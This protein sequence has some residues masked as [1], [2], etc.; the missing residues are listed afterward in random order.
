MQIVNQEIY[1]YRRNKVV[2][3]AEVEDYKQIS[4][5]LLATAMKNLEYYGYTFS[6]SL[7]SAL[8]KT[9]KEL[10]LEWMEE[11]NCILDDMVGFKEGMY[12]LFEDFPLNLMTSSESD[13]Y[14]MSL[15]RYL[16]SGVVH[17]KKQLKKNY[18]LLDNPK[19][20][21]IDLGSEDDFLSIFTNLLS[22]KTAISETDKETISWFVMHP[23]MPLSEII[24]TEI[25]NKENLTFITITMRESGLSNKKLLNNYKTATDVLRFAVAL[26]GG[27]ISLKEKTKFKSFKRSDRRL[28]LS[29]LEN[30]PFI[31]ED[32][33]RRKSEWIRLGEKLHPAEYKKF[34]KVNRAFHKLRN[35]KP[36]KTFK[37]ELEKHFSN[38]DLEKVLFLLSKRPGEF[39]RQLDRT[40]RLAI[41]LN[42]LKGDMSSTLKVMNAFREV[43]DKIET[44]V[45]LQLRQHLMNRTKERDFRVFYPKGSMAKAYGVENQIQPLS[46]DIVLEFVAIC[47][48]ALISKYGE[49]EDMGKVFISDE[50]K[51]YVVPMSQRNASKTLRAVARGS[52]FKIEEDNDIVRAFI[53]WKQ[54]SEHTWGVDVDLSAV[55]YDED[56][57]YI[58]DIS[59]CHLEGK[60]INAK[61][62]G[63]VRSAPKGASEYIDM[64][65]N[66]LIANDVKYVSFVI[67]SF[68]E[69]LFSELPEC[70]AGF[71]SREDIKSGEVYEPKTVINKSDIASNSYQVIPMILDVENR[72][73]IWADL[74]VTKMSQINNVATNKSALLYNLKSI[75]NTEK[76]NLYDLILLNVLGRGEVV[77]DKEDADIV[78]S[79]NEGIT[80]YDTDIIIGE[81]L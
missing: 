58:E 8:L 44:T 6:D 47:D 16:S 26:S 4:S 37:S 57:N 38:K 53:Y 65:I 19:L 30:I 73:M 25:P 55:C 11:V 62:S 49:K 48:V 41:E 79:V 21:V 12:P 60:M 43:A 15:K 9:S 22:S 35:N 80:P 64:S 7:M 32:M 31:E 20:K 42:G 2:A 50:L 18:P 10:F 45:L 56:F 28:I 69:E 17:T 78:F 29:L 40:L 46:E 61:H 33:Y 36:I 14:L 74:T 1:L 23:Y 54:G 3:P 24:P 13:G 76:P 72:E 67:N 27:D 63:D 70:F 52:K 34:T 5:N 71:M 81:Y 75:V 77:T 68:S 66:N 39:A 59:Y 51:N